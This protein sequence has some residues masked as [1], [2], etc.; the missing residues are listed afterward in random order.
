MLKRPGC[1]KFVDLLPVCATCDCGGV[2]RILSKRCMTHDLWSTL[3]KKMHAYLDSVSLLDLVEKQNAREAHQVKVLQDKRP[4]VSEGAD[5]PMPV[6][7]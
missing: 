4:A 5:K 1:D 7:A 2:A 6:S 3:N